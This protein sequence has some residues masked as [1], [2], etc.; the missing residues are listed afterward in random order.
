[1]FAER[2]QYLGT[3]LGVFLYIYLVILY[4]IVPTKYYYFPNFFPKKIDKQKS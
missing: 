1:M 3:D 2:F 4:E